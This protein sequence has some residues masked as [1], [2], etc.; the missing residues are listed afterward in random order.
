MSDLSGA[1]P[2]ESYFSQV[3][4]LFRLSVVRLVRSPHAPL[5]AAAARR[6][7]Q[8]ALVLAVGGAIAIVAL[9]LMFDAMEI[10]LMP[11]RGTPSLWP[12][13]ILTDFGKDEFVLW[14]LA[15]ALLV[16]GLVVP[17]LQ[18]PPRKR[19]QRLGTDVQYLFFAV[20]VS[21]LTAQ[22]IKWVVGRGRPFVGGKAD[23]LNFAPFN[24]T[25]AYFSLP[26]SHAVTA[27]ALAFAV[28]AVWPKTR[29]VMA[30][31]ALAI[32]ASR[33]V[34]LAH[35]PSDVVAGGLLGVIGAMAMRYWFAARQIGFAIEDHGEIV[36]R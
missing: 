24:G 27:C 32:M 36:S 7:G 31:Y 10:G 35:H 3:S 28:A 13:R 25:E 26:S 4:A 12:V 1:A 33:L 5:R 6:L 29:I 15:V 34:L 22:V 9:M 21:V 18:G 23:P 20:L 16:I 2:T 30:V 11:P 17:L 14:P 8:Q 19:L